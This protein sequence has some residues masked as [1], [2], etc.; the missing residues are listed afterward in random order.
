MRYKRIELLSKGWKPLIL[1]VVRIPQMHLE[2][3][4][5]SI[6]RVS[7]DCTSLC[8]TDA[9]YRDKI[10]ITEVSADTTIPMMLNILLTKCF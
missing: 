3:F 5:P 1:T 7:V 4:E 8:A 9:M 6:F 10:S 2:G